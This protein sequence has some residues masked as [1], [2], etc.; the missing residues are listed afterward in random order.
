[1]LETIRKAL[2]EYIR[3]KNCKTCEKFDNFLLAKTCELCYDLIQ[4]YFQ[5]W[6]VS[7]P[8]LC[9][10]EIIL[11]TSVCAI[12]ESKPTIAKE[13]IRIYE[14]VFTNTDE[15]FAVC[16]LIKAEMLL[17]SVNADMNNLDAMI[18]L[19]NKCITISNRVKNENILATA[20]ATLYRAIYVYLRPSTRPNAIKYLKPIVKL[21]SESE[22]KAYKWQ[23][24]FIRILLEAYIQTGQRKDASHLVDV[25]AGGP[26]RHLPQQMVQLLV[27]ASASNLASAERNISWASGVSGTS[28]TDATGSDKSTVAYVEGHKRTN[29]PQMSGQLAQTLLQSGMLP[30]NRIAKLK[31]QNKETGDQLDEIVRLLRVLNPSEESTEGRTGRSEQL[32]VPVTDSK[33]TNDSTGAGMTAGED[34]WSERYQ[35]F[36]DDTFNLLFQLG[37]IAVSR[38]LPGVVTACDPVSAEVNAELLNLEL[39]TME[40]DFRLDSNTT[41]IVQ[42]HLQLAKRCEQL[43]EQ[44]IRTKANNETIQ[45]GCVTL[46]NICLPLLQKTT[47]QDQLV[48]QCLH[49]IVETLDQLQSLHF[50]LR[51]QAH[52]MLAKC[53]ADMEKLPQALAHLE[54]VFTFDDTDEFTEG[55]IHMYNRLQLRATIYEIPDRIEDRAAQ[56]LEHLRSVTL[57]DLSARK[58]AELFQTGTDGLFE[59]NFHPANGQSQMTIR[60]LL[61]RVGETLA[62]NCFLT[63]LERETLLTE[64]LRE[65]DR[66][67]TD[68]HS[69]SG[70][71]TSGLYT[72]EVVRQLANRAEQ[73]QK[74]METVQSEAV[75]QLVQKSKQEGTFKERLLLWMDLAKVAR[76][77][78]LWDMC[79]LACRFGLQYD[80]DAVWSDIWSKIERGKTLPSKSGG[81]GGE[82]SS[83]QKKTV[84]NA[85]EPSPTSGTD[86]KPKISKG[87]VKH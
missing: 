33:R 1:M 79:T 54:K 71:I 62:P 43:V 30:A 68:R 15:L 56:I 18:K 61:S 38:K 27:R 34:D 9:P 12:K 8:F 11:Y 87:K 46:W 51:C 26:A 21:L 74:C 84:G 81:G 35:F 58:L 80:T 82:Q 28:D 45:T 76:R 37:L 32:S 14:E 83:G 47:R 36:P 25:A 77:F 5:T 70:T 42:S 6:K 52:L 7:Q 2:N 4:N 55:A 19:I 13:L 16:Q 29:Y 48:Q 22:A 63:A 67:I 24:L 17:P 75:Q 31:V 49:L 39:E 60:D 65:Q 53:L 44:A 69:I 41:A 57:E 50:R 23:I 10:P 86:K 64:T 73:W 3:D 78:H 66:L 85:K 20:C 59:K 40:E 72:G